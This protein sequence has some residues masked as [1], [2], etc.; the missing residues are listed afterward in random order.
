MVLAVGTNSTEVDD[1]KAMV[2]APAHG[3]LDTGSDS[4]DEVPGDGPARDLALELE[5]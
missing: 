4:G 2:T 1:R 3:L 5:S